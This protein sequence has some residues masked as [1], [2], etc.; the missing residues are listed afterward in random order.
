MPL[1][2]PQA[3]T[4]MY[5]DVGRLINQSSND[6]MANQLGV[7][8]FLQDKQ[9]KDIQ[10]EDAAYKLKDTRLEQERLDKPITLSEI[11]TAFGQKWDASQVATALPPVLDTFTKS[12]GVTIEDD[13]TFKTKEGKPLTVRDASRMGGALSAL[14]VSYIDPESAIAGKRAQLQAAAVANPEDVATRDALHKLE[15]SAQDLA[16][17]PLPVYEAKL[18]AM[19]KVLGQIGDWGGN[20]KIIESERGKLLGQIDMELKRRYDE[21][22][23]LPLKLPDGRTIMIGAHDWA[24]AQG[25]LWKREADLAKVNADKEKQRYEMG[26]TP[27]KIANIRRQTEA[28]VDTAIK[29]ALDPAG[30]LPKPQTTDGEPGG[31]YS[32]PEIAAIKQGEVERRMGGIRKEMADAASSYGIGKFATGKKPESP[33]AKI[34]DSDAKNFASSMSELGA[35]VPAGWQSKPGSAEYNTAVAVSKA[36]QEA[37]ALMKQNKVTEAFKLLSEAKATAKQAKEQGKVQGDKDIKKT[38]ATSAPSW[39]SP[40]NVEDYSVGGFQTGDGVESPVPGLGVGRYEMVTPDPNK[41]GIFSG[42]R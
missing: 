1:V 7:A 38:I 35:S 26:I 21:S 41:L 16:K 9:L 18:R 40:S 10:T 30:R 32:P 23:K 2:G 5:T 24:T 4:G 25:N 37:T 34:S 31:F 12:L 36:M 42:T 13:G 8:K 39:L 3:I 14:A 19:D 33:A 11:S 20:T 15:V 28:D 29:S 27:E 17:N 6:Y 22:Q